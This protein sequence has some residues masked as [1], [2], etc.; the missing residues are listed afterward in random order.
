[1]YPS[2]AYNMYAEV[3][4]SGKITNGP[5]VAFTTGAWPS[6][7]PLPP[8]TVADGPPTNDPNPIIL[9]NFITFVTGGTNK[10][11]PDVVTD[12]NGNVMWY[13]YSPIPPI[14]TGTRSVTGGGIIT[15]QDDLR[16]GSADHPG[17]ISRQIDFA[18]NVVRETNM[19]AIQQELIALGAVDG[20]S[21]TGI[22]NPTVGTA[23]AG[24]FHHDAIQTLP[25]GYMAA[26]L[27]IER[28]YPTGTQGDTQGLPVDIIGD[29]IIVMNSNWQ[30]V[31]YWDAF[32]PN[33]GGQGYPQLP[34]TQTA[35]MGETC[36]NSTSGC[37]PMFLLGSNI[38]PLAHD[39]LHANSLYYWPSPHDG[40]KTAGDI[41]WSSRH[42][43]RVYKIDY[44]DGAGTGNILW[45]MGP[46][47]DGLVYTSSFTFTNTYNDVWPWFSHQHSVGMQHGGAGPMTLFDNGDTRVEAAPPLGLGGPTPTCGKYDCDSRGMALKVQEPTGGSDNGIV[48]PDISLDLRSVF[49]RHG[50]RRSA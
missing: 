7:I 39:W 19:G 11:Y 1:M 36:G 42:Q 13:Y 30:V 15:L 14:A 6:G 31:W 27:D 17:T 28:I 35:P 9:H 44:R 43:D 38:S 22:T 18:G 40:N 26:L 46:Q 12:L 21:C 3:K 50:Q 33:N 16:P 20:G 34:I 32:D 48:T 49:N 8:F 23:C 2:T 47:D 37:P 5:T 4:T 10:V 45:Q 41:I 29:M 25:N 24:S